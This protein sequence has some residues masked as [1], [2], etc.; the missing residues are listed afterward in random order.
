MAVWQGFGVNYKAAQAHWD[1]D[2]AYFR[3]IGLKYIRP[4]MPGT[5][6]P[7]SVGTSDSNGNHAFWRACAQYFHNAGFWVTWGP[8]YSPIT[9]SN[10]QSVHNTIVAEAQYLQQQGIVVD[11][12]EVG[13]EYEGAVRLTITSLVQSAGLA[14]AVVSKPHQFQT[15][16]SVTIYGATPAG[17]NGTYTITVTNS[18]TFTFSVD[19]SLVSPATWAFAI[20]CYSM[21]L[22]QLNANIRQLAADVKA[23]YHLGQ[24]SYACFNQKLTPENVFGYSDWIANG[25][26]ALD[27]ISIHPY[28]S[29]NPLAQ[30]ITSSGYAYIAEMANAFGEAC[31]ISEFNLD[32]SSANLAAEPT[33]LE[34]TQMTTFFETITNAGLSKALLYEFTPYLSRVVSDYPFSSVY[35]SGA[36]NPMWFDF[37]DS[38]P[39]FYTARQANAARSPTARPPNIIRRTATRMLIR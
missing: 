25:I 4:H 34:A 27:T 13:N 10:W 5:N 6:I 21:S 8:S 36:V 20:Y 23:V 14:T 33:P 18:T 39:M 24:V 16:D 9:T 29:I 30:T 31:Y 7:W 37:F 38:Q 28:A 2:I 35:P 11:E 26:G 3:S 1:A 15:G 32:G 12:F 22:T 19:S 17:Y